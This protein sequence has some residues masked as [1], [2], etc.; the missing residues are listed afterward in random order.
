MPFLEI[1][2]Q[3]VYISNSRSSFLNDFLFKDKDDLFLRSSRLLN[4]KA[5]LEHEKVI[6]DYLE[7]EYTN[8]PEAFYLNWVCFDIRDDEATDEVGFLL[9]IYCMFSGGLSL[10]DPDGR[11]IEFVYSDSGIRHPVFAIACN[12]GK[13][14]DREINIF[15]ESK[16]VTR[17]VGTLKEFTIYMEDFKLICGGNIEMRYAESSI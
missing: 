3:N 17:I 5:R 6:T 2:K 12:I 8:D 15:I 16:R 7:R 1:G 10:L 4:S 11:Q 13:I 14:K 9:D